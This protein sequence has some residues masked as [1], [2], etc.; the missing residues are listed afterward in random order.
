MRCTGTIHLPHE[1]LRSAHA[2]TRSMHYMQAG[3][4]CPQHQHVNHTAELKGSQCGGPEYTASHTMIRAQF[5][6]QRIRMHKLLTTTGCNYRLLSWCNCCRLSKTLVSYK[7]GLASI[8][9]NGHVLRSLSGLNHSKGIQ[10]PKQGMGARVAPQSVC[11]VHYPY[12]SLHLFWQMKAQKSVR[13]CT[14]I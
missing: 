13:S 2:T 1:L 12:A 10:K 6:A 9:N 3:T 7:N 8:F 14:R 4:Y 11:N 5:E